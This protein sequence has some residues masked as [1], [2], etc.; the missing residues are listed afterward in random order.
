MP[1]SLEFVAVN[2]CEA[3]ACFDHVSINKLWHHRIQTPLVRRQQHVRKDARNCMTTEEQRQQPMRRSCSRA[4]ELWRLQMT[5]NWQKQ[6][7]HRLQARQAHEYL[8]HSP[9][10]VRDRSFT[11]NVE[12]SSHI[13]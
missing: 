7:S 3:H 10:W 1:F 8:A 11:S 13:T 4:A 9:E 6:R 2:I 12:T 5:C